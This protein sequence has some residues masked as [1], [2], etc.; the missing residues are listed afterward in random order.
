MICFRVFNK[1]G[2]KSLTLRDFNEKV[3]Q[4]MLW[5]MD[6]LTRCSFILQL[7]R[8][9]LSSTLLSLPK[10]G[11]QKLWA[12]SDKSGQH[13]LEPNPETRLS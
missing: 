13:F 11:V 1:P 10:K 12:P 9:G 8:L 6:N 5:S 7:L 3:K 2:V 4:L